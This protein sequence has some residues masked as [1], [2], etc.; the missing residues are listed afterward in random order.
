MSIRALIVIAL[1]MFFLACSAPAPLP[2]SRTGQ[3][4]RFLATKTSSD[5]DRKIDEMAKQIGE[6]GRSSL[7]RLFDD[8]TKWRHY[9]E[10]FERHWSALR[11]E[12]KAT[13]AGRFLAWCQETI[14]TPGGYGRFR[15]AF[16]GRSG[17]VI[18]PPLNRIVSGTD[19][20]EGDRRRALNFAYLMDIKL[21]MRLSKETGFRLQSIEDIRSGEEKRVRAG[22]ETFANLPEFG[23]QGQ[24]LLQCLFRDVPETA[25]AAA[26]W[27]GT[28]PDSVVKA[29]YE[30]Q[31]FQK[32]G[33]EFLAVKEDVLK[34]SGLAE[35]HQSLAGSYLYEKQKKP[36]VLEAIARSAAVIL[37]IRQRAAELALKANGYALTPGLRSIEDPSVLPFKY[38]LM[39]AAESLQGDERTEEIWRLLLAEKT[40]RRLAR[41]IRY[42][43][44]T[45]PEVFTK[46]TPPRKALCEWLNAFWKIDADIVKKLG[47]ARIENYNDTLKASHRALSE[48]MASA[49]YG[50]SLQTTT[51]ALNNLLETDQA[52]QDIRAQVRKWIGKDGKKFKKRISQ[53]HRLKGKIQDSA[54]QE[55]A[56]ACQT[57]FTFKSAAVLQLL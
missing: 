30:S 56:R 17:Q 46:Q 11:P 35:F 24:Y 4:D 51:N 28:Y 3:P 6:D 21:G 16:L 2:G 19:L 39:M 14:E 25:K 38:R 27:I 26:P 5:V 9:W 52:N 44:E 7:D 43:L 53:L 47:Y 36:E 15:D 10:L 12:T 13:L 18:W 48:S 22:I 49:Q 45:H 50:R 32:N 33:K 1:L 41:G 29:I 8:D 55:I 37:Q 42:L 57:V 40:P 23:G 54:M 34:R 31:K 20:S